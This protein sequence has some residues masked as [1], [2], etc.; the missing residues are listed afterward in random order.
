RKDDRSTD[1]GAIAMRVFR[2]GHAAHPNWRTAV[3]VL[4]T[5]LDGVQAS[6]VAGLGVLYVT[7]R[8]AERLGDIAIVLGERFPAVQWV[9]ASAHGVC[10]SGVEYGEDSALAAMI[11]ELPK[12]S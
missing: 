7:E 1:R 3:E 4:L 10:A 9:G 11:C 8:L 12:G 6:S 5:Q 2:H